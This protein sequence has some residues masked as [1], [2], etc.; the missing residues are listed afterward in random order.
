MLFFAR[1]AAFFL[2]DFFAVA[3]DA[4]ARAAVFLRAVLDG[5]VVFLA[6]FLP[7][8]LV[9][10]RATGRFFTVLVFFA[11]GASNSGVCFFSLRF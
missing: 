4:A 10:F 1:L 2:A 5:E 9:A 11:T 3:R 8:A 6:D 7:A